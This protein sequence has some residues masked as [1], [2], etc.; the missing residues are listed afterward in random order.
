MRFRFV[1]R[2]IEIWPGP[3]RT[4]CFWEMS[5]LAGEGCFSG[6]WPGHAGEHS[7]A[8]TGFGGVGQLVPG[9][10]RRSRKPRSVLVGQAW[11]SKEKGRK[12]KGC[13]TMSCEI[14]QQNDL[15]EPYTSHLN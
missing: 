7:A 11:F 2:M 5:D 10:C 9:E 15:E 14:E 8:G 3:K 12:A 1:M 4:R 6:L 13:R